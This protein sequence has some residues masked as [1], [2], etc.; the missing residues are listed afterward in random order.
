MPVSENRVSP[1][2]SYITRM[3]SS[4]MLTVQLQWP[5]PGGGGVCPGG[6]VSAC[7]GGGVLCARHPTPVDSNELYYIALY[8]IT[9]S[10]ERNQ[11]RYEPNLEMW[12]APVLYFRKFSTSFV[13][14]TTN[15]VL[16]ERKTSIHCTY[17]TSL[18]NQAAGTVLCD[19]C[20]PSSRM[21]TTVT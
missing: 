11:H 3:H 15:W 16:W 4:R 8:F 14:L 2:G 9:P 5:S 18:W 20:T 6:G 17:L 10:N 19:P 12:I 21:V 7:G 13:I 1:K